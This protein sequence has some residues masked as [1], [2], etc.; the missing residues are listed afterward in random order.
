MQLLGQ[1]ASRGVALVGGMLAGAAATIPLR[2]YLPSAEEEQRQKDAGR[3]LESY[4]DVLATMGSLAFVGSAGIAAGLARRAT[5]AQ[6]VPLLLLGAAGMF[7]S[8]AGTTLVK[9]ENEGRSHIV[10]LGLLTGVAGLAYLVGATGRVPTGVAQNAALAGLGVFAGAAGLETARW[11]GEEV[12]LLRDSVRWKR[13]N[14][15]A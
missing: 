13:A 6:S 15:G 12:G 8:L 4:D 2:H 10:S 11:L 1:P 5:G 9:S 14:D 7:T 3:E